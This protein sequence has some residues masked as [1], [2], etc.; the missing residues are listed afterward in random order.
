MPR[1][2]LGA[3]GH[4]AKSLAFASSHKVQKASGIGVQWEASKIHPS[5]DDEEMIWSCANACALESRHLE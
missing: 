4:K 2:S 3:T 5:G 1:P